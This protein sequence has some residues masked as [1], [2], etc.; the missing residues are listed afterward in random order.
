MQFKK[1]LSIHQDQSSI[2][3]TTKVKMITYKI[4]NINDYGEDA[5]KDWIKNI[6]QK[7]RRRFKV[8]TF[9]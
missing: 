6:R 1:Y 7:E 4:V 3:E 5:S 8:G 2:F 9:H